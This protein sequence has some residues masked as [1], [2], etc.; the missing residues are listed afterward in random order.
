MSNQQLVSL[1]EGVLPI[2]ELQH[3]SDFYSSP[4]IAVQQPAGSTEIQQPTLMDV[5][6][7]PAPEE[8]SAPLLSTSTAVTA[9]GMS[10]ET[11]VEIEDSSDEEDVGNASDVMEADP[12]P[13]A[14]EATRHRSWTPRTAQPRRS[15]C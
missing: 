1:M 5:P 8:P 14:K 13:T 4:V 7:T 3:I 6:E 9:P 2:S 15:R 10:I 12:P 11:A